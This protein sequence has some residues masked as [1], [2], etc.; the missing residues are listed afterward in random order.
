ML[1]V[2]V[3]LFRDDGG[4]DFQELGRLFTS[5]LLDRLHSMFRVPFLQVGKKKL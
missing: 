2:E 1:D 5:D 3:E 4:D